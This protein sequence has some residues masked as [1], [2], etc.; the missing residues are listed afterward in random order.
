MM[1]Y[2]RILQ[3]PLLSEARS[4]RLARQMHGLGLCKKKLQLMSWSFLEQDISLMPCLFHQEAVR[5]RLLAIGFK[6][7]CVSSCCQAA[8]RYLHRTAF[9]RLAN[10]GLP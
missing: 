8:S 7:K 2:S 1:S 9:K 3:V 4:R 5:Y 10:K 6:A